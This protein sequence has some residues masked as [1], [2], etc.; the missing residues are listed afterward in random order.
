MP[1]E[2]VNLNQF[3]KHRERTEK[4]RQ[5]MANRKKFGRTKTEKQG[6]YKDAERVENQLSGHEI[7]DE[8]EPA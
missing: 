2:I 4:N 7:D 8:P 3:R 5:T 6:E 1:A